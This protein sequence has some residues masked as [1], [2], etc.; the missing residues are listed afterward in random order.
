MTTFAVQDDLGAMLRRTFDLG[1]HL[2]SWWTHDDT[3]A[4]FATLD[5]AEAIARKVRDGG[6][7]FGAQAVEVLA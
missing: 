7:R 4:R 5:E 6:Y 2:S 1:E 3:F